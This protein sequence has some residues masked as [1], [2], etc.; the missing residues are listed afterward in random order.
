MTEKQ[1]PHYDLAAVKAAFADPTR[2]NR[3]FAS[4]RGAFALDIDDAGVVAIVQALRISD[5]DKAMTSY[6]DH[7]IWQDVY[8]PMRDGRTLYV[9][10]T[11]DSA[12]EFL[13][14]SFKES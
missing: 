2:L 12:G 5:F 14:I 1:K 4:R 6:S 13:L 10:F 9:K 11:V 7:K 8:K 3:S